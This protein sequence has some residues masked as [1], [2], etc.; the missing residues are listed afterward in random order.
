MTTIL[1]RER[2]LPFQIADQKLITH[3]FCGLLP[4]GIRVALQSGRLVKGN[5]GLCWDD[6]LIK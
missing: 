2:M 5:Y 1:W 6:E 4:D 3:L